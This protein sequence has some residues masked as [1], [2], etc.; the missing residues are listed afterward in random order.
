MPQECDRDVKMVE[1]RIDLEKMLGRVKDSD[2]VEKAF[3]F[4]E[5]GHSGQKRLDGTDFLLHPYRVALELS[6]WNMDSVTVASGLLHDLVEDTDVTGEQIKHEFGAEIAG[7]VQALTKIKEIPAVSKN[8]ENL[9]RLI[10][11]MGRD[12]RVIMVRLADKLDN[13]RT[14]GFLEEMNDLFELC[15][16]L[17]QTSHILE[18]DLH[19]LFADDFGPILPKRQHTALGHLAHAFHDHAPDQQH[20]TDRQDPGQQNGPKALFLDHASGSHPLFLE[21]LD[22]IGFLYSDRLK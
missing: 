14:V 17:V 22:K 7:I 9:R 20:N 15:F 11:A 2:L 13:I 19:I 10:I 12:V 16:G 1:K 21:V 6:G 5:A 8:I 18:A 4:A 3:R